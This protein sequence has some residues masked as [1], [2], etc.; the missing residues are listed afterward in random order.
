[1]VAMAEHAN[2]VATYS[3]ISNAQEAHKGGIV[4]LSN[5]DAYTGQA[6]LQS[7]GNESGVGSPKLQNH[8]NASDIGPIDAHDRDDDILQN[9][10]HTD[11]DVDEGKCVEIVVPVSGCGPEGNLQFYPP[12]SASHDEVISDPKLFISTLEDFLAALGMTLK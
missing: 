3:Q 10:A 1:M 8:R 9:G 4:G 5:D 2:K 7:Y 12:P 11:A 6:T